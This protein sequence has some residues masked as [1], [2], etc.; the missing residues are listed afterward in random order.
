[1]PR[2][3]QE[4]TSSHPATDTSSALR[5]ACDVERSGLTDDQVAC[6]ADLIADGQDTFPTD[7]TP[8]DHDRL[9]TQVRSRLRARLAR[10][11]VRQIAS[12]IKRATGSQ[13]CS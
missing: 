6:W 13:S 1:M 9:L 3:S 7:L 4:R 11:V 2:K 8:Q 12:D 5:T 10:F